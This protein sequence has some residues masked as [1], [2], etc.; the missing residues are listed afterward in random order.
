MYAM[1]ILCEIAQKK[2]GRPY[3]GLRVRL[4]VLFWSLLMFRTTAQK[5]SRGIL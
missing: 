5:Y 3:G 1:S 2:E 4:C